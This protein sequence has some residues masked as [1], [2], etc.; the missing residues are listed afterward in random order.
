MFYGVR[1]FL[2]LCLLGGLLAC[3]PMESME[4]GFHTTDR[5]YMNQLALAMQTADIQFRLDDQGF[6]RYSQGDSAEV[7]KIMEQLDRRPRGGTAVNFQD[8]EANTYFRSLLDSL[9]FE[10]LV[11]VRNDGEWTRWHPENE[12]QAKELH[13]KVV[14]WQFAKARALAK[15]TPCGKLAGKNEALAATGSAND[16][17]VD[18]HRP[19]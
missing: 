11:E 13:R 4:E 1:V 15:K 17:P 18:T 12:A 3:T 8:S 19:C 10:Y 6:I 7:E 9:G 2:I 16:A 14:E 5:E